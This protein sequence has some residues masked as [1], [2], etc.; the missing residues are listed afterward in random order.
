MNIERFVQSIKELPGSEYIAGARFLKLLE[1]EIRGHRSIVD[2]GA[3]IGTISIFASTVNP[4]IEIQAV[5]PF[6]WCQEQYETNIQKL[7]GLELKASSVPNFDEVSRGALWVV[8]IEFSTNHLDEI[9]STIPS[10][11]WVEGHRYGQ[12]KAIA[13]RALATGQCFSYQSFLGFPGSIKGGC[14]FREVENTW[15]N[16]IK[17]RAAILRMQVI[18]SMRLQILEW[19]LTTRIARSK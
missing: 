11:I 13:R 9:L 15:L 8:D 2:Y 3:G 12:R 5:E 18:T 6:E 4:S 16:R 19:E 1:P 7:C 10:Q 17:L 14:C